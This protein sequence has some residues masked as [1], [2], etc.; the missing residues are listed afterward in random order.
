M[1]TRGKSPDAD[2]VGIEIV[3]GGIGSKPSDRSLAI[4]DLCWKRCDLCKAII[5][6]RDRISFVY[7]PNSRTLLFSAAVPASTVNPNNYGQRHGNLLRRVEVERENCAVNALVNQ[8]SLDCGICY[9]RWPR[10]S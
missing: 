4:F 7:N 8:I 6:A 3:F 5:N 10:L 2:P 1:P 9:L